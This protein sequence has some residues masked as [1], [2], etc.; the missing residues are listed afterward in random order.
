[1]SAFLLMPIAARAVEVAT[2]AAFLACWTAV[3][4]GAHGC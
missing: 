2:W 4:F 1:M 3:L